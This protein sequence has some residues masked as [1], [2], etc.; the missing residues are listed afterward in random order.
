VYRKVLKSFFKD[1]YKQKKKKKMRFLENN[2]KFKK[3]IIIKTKEQLLLEKEQA[4][5][6]KRI[7]ENL[8]SFKAKYHS[9][10]YKVHKITKK[11]FI[12]IKKRKQN[13]R[14]SLLKR[15]A[16]MLT[17]IKLKKR[18][19]QK[20]KIILRR[21]FKGNYKERKAAANKFYISLYKNEKK[22]R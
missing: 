3:K 18:K 9:I 1:K 15:F 12:F 4:F 8:Q 14:L 11:R 7:S 21:K 13:D 17:Y 22:I 10:K 2:G 20:T 16:F 19:G 5:F 6:A